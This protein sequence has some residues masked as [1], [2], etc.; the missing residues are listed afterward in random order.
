MNI[1]QVVLGNVLIFVLYLFL[2][3]LIGRLVFDLV[4]MYAR[5]WR[6]AGLVL[7]LAETVYTVT[8]PPLKFLRR[9]IKPIRL[10]SVALDLSFMIL[11]L[12]VSILLQV[13]TSVVVTM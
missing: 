6:P 4:Q 12:V 13:V 1:V 5:S 7:V 8:D 3:A 11:F 2:F 10:G 9:F